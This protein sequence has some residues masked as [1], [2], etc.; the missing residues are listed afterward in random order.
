[1]TDNSQKII[2][3]LC[4]GTGAWSLPYKSAGY[5]VRLVTLPEYDV[6]TYSPPDNVY[7]VLAA[8]PCN[9]FARQSTRRNLRRGMEI[10]TAC[11]NIIWECQ[12]QKI[13]LAFWALENPN[14][15]LKRFM[16]KPALIF[17]PLDYGNKGMKTTCLWG[18]FNKPVPT[19]IP[20]TFDEKA[21]QDKHHIHPFPSAKEYPGVDRAGRRA[22]T[23][24][25]FARA[26]FEANR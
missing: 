2:L 14:G 8:P 16:G 25:D 26:F 13:G 12:Y 5:D 7:G 19:P 18:K 15:M 1:M 17:Q 9:D 20:M 11:L 21:L 23:P 24:P 3:D 6:R 22:I 4:G 10:V